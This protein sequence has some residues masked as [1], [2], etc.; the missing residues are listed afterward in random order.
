[1]GL[2]AK[3]AGA[4]WPREQPACMSPEVAVPRPTGRPHFVAWRL[5]LV[6]RFC[7]RPAQQGAALRA[8]WPGAAS[9][10]C[11]FKHA[12]APAAPAC[13]GLGPA[14]NGWCHVCIMWALGWVLCPNRTQPGEWQRRA[15]ESGAAR[16]AHAAGIA[17]SGAPCARAEARRAATQPVRSHLAA[18]RGRKLNTS[19]MAGRPPSLG[20][21]VTGCCG[22]AHRSWARPR[23]RQRPAAASAS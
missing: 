1:M 6:Q 18:G 4:G 7:R 9:L 16:R 23:A 10:M 12:P 19:H 5:A 15:L 2:V 3:L 22:A 20:T 17:G 21:P 13:G 14:R 8:R 11:A